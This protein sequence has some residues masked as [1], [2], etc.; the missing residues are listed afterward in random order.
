MNFSYTVT[1]VVLLYL[2]GITMGANIGKEER[3]GIDQ[4][5]VRL[6]TVD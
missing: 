4:D 5:S 2:F 6:F 3:G 1:S